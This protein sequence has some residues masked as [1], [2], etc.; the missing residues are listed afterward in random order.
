M[1]CQRCKEREATVQIMQQI[2]SKKA[3]TFYLCEVCAREL[4]ITMPAFPKI[5]KMTSNP[6]SAAGNVFQ[7]SFGFGAE[8]V[9]T[10]QTERCDQCGLTF[11]E[12][13]K[14]GYLGCTG[15][16]EAFAHLMDPVFVRTQMGKKHMGR[17]LGH[18]SDKGIGDDKEKRSSTAEAAAKIKNES[19]EAAGTSARKRKLTAREPAAA[20]SAEESEELIALE[21]QHLENLL[22]EKKDALAKAVAAEEYMTAA[23][24]RDE[25]AD[26]NKKKEG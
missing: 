12:F 2:G 26:L 5:G 16:Y 19:G 6:F 17:K 7:S 22:K 9:K 1:K 25:I 21:K 4:G 13:R 20:I 24:I 3:Q 23:K 18:R 15:C 10:K 11:E 14:S 8:E